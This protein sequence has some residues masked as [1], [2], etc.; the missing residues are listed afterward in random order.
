MYNWSFVV[1]SYALTW[2]VVLG[3]TLYIR[4]RTLRAEGELIAAAA[5]VEVER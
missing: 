5:L 1:A 3:Y 2:T 4:S